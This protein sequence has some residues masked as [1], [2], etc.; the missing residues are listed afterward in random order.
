[1]RSRIRWTVVA[2]VAIS[3]A[4]L[5]VWKVLPA[6]RAA[7]TAEEAPPPTAASTT[8]AAPDPCPRPYSDTSPWNSRIGASPRYHPASAFHVSVLR[9]NLTSDPTQYT[10]PVYRVSAATPVA[11][12][13][14]S[15][16]YSNVVDGGATLRNERR[17]VARIPMPDGAQ[18]AAGD[19]AQIILVDEASGDEWGMS[20]LKREAD[21]RWTAWNAYHYNLR[22][23]G[24]PPHDDEA[25]PFFPRGAGVPY[26]AGLV[27]PCEIGRGRIDHA[28][29]FAY[30]FP[31]SSFVHPA[32]KSD[33]IG[34]KPEDMPQGSRL[35]L[36]PSFTEE[37]IKA[38]GCTGACL[39]TARA[40]Q[41]YGMY[42]IDN[43]G[44]PKVMFEYEGTASWGG[45]VTA[46][47]VSPIPLDGFRLLGPGT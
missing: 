10:Y 40:L 36:D 9:G 3:A 32:T 21:G 27:R 19:D 39:T 8:S 23:D 30:K 1:M 15:G 28:L 41:E 11:E 43:A 33:G 6:D 29:A 25:R 2:L 5:G 24:V 18:A 31:T 37:Q 45:A 34:T 42:I 20:H 22:W 26:L 7:S 12:V 44:R 13:F 4:A 47:T 35:Q 17:G 38:W 46:E 16:W 14:T